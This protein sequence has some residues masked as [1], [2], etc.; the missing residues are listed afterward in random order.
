MMITVYGR[1]TSVNVQTV[2]W[3]IAELGLDHERID[4][5]AAVGKTET[6]E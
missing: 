5:G 2:M 4:Y 3:C 6:A 1:N